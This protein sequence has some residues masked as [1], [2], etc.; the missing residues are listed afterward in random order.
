MQL[1]GADIDCVNELGAAGEQHFGEAAGRGAD[2]EAGTAG[3]VEPEMIERGGELDAA[4]RHIGVLGRSGD[5][6]GGGNSFGGFAHGLSVGGYP[7]G[8]NRGLRPRPAVEQAARDQQPIGS[9]FGGHGSY[10][11]APLEARAKR[12][13]K[14]DGPG[15]ASFEGRFAAT[16]G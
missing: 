1:P 5:D 9:F 8:G 7:A 10:R 16:S 2:I 15:R 6:R 14:G 3:N 12:A 13:S 4:A 11:V